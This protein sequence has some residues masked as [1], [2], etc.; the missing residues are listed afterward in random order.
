MRRQKCLNENCRIAKSE[1]KGNLSKALKQKKVSKKEAK[2]DSLPKK[3][4]RKRPK[5]NAIFALNH[6]CLIEVFRYLSMNDLINLVN[7]S[8]KFLPSAVKAYGLQ[9][10]HEVLSIY[11]QPDT[12]FIMRLDCQSFYGTYTLQEMK[13]FFRNFGA[14]VNVIEI[15]HGPFEQQLIYSLLKSISKYCC[16]SV[17]DLRLEKFK[18][19]PRIMKCL[20]PL[21]QILKQLTLYEC[22]LNRL[23]VK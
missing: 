15:E 1:L 16:K 13:L 17:T 18:V 12:T 22:D 2:N 23:Q 14:A 20:Q 3:V 8:Q 6:D 21:Q 4:K 19:T 11:V 5:E 10:R 9:Y 7:A